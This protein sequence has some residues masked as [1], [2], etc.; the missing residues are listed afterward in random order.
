MRYLV[1]VFLFL[2]ILTK[3]FSQTETLYSDYVYEPGIKTVKLYRE[4]FDLSS[5]ILELNKNDKLV[6]TF[7]DMAKDVK[8]F[9]Y[10]VIHCNADWKPS[11]LY[12]S[13]YIEGYTDD[14][15]VNYAFSFNT[16]QRYVHYTLNFPNEN[17]RV[18]KS[19]NYILKVYSDY[20]PEKLVLT[21]RFMVVDQKIGI[22]AGVKRAIIINDRNT[23]QQIHFSIYNKNYPINDAYSDLHVILQ[24]NQR[25]DNLITDLKPLFIKDDQLIYN[26]DEGNTFD[27][28]NEF[29]YFDTRSFRFLSERIDHFDFDSLKQNH[30]YLYGDDVR[31]FKRYSTYSDLNGRFK[32]KIQEGNN[33]ELESDYGYVHFSLPYE[34][35]VP[36]GKLFIFGGLTDW[37]IRSNNEL[38]YNKEKKAYEGILYLKQGY[39]NYHYAFVGDKEKVIDPT[40]I[41]GNHYET[42][43]DYTIYVYH[44]AIG[45]RYDQLIGIRQLN[46]LQP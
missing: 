38:K 32:I 18:T 34:T 16:L 41:E 31:R 22:E 37:Q 29:R 33:S 14:R 44:R 2:G 5:P 4:G 6:L 1:L 35:P 28:L 3:V 26:Q 20:D 43:N 17:I 15:I 25:W 13:E 8:T 7:D 19:G 40:F 30:V 24:Q 9:N 46:S 42:E 12:T 21:R 39:Y 11:S 36:D 45:T 23:K 27:G 10:T